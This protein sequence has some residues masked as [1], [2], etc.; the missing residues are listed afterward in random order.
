M[1]DQL[2]PAYRAAEPF[3]H[4]VIDNF[5]PAPVMADVQAAFPRPGE[6]EWQ[7]FSTSQE[8]KLASDDVERMTPVIRH[9]LREF[10][11]AS[12]VNFLE[13][14]TGI[15]GLVPDPHYWGGGLHQIER[16][17]HLAI[18]ADFNRHERLQLDRRL[19]LLLYLNE[20]WQPEWGGALELWSRDMSRCCHSILPVAN[21]CV[22]FDTGDTSFHGHPEPLAC[23]PDRTRRSLALY[24][25]T[26]GRPPGDVSATRTTQFQARPDETWKRP[27]FDARRTAQR[28]LPPVVLDAART[29]RDR[30][31]AR[32]S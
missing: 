31:T 29:M 28:L 9:L 30:A 14:L 10:N 4:T 26:N 19:N 13:R 25:Y 16:G 23:P 32:R 24:Y 6:L 20:D 27:P 8:R 22:I 17:G 5:L 2:G 18:H 15:D 1:A 12:M 11:S 7:E 3:P 21:R